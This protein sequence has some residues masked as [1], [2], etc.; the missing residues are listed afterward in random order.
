MKRLIKYLLLAFIVVSTSYLIAKE[1]GWL[2]KEHNKA[3]PVQIQSDGIFAYY[4]HGSKRCITCKTI[5]AYLNEAEDIKWLA[6]DVDLPENEHYIY[7]FNLASSTAV[8]AKYKDGKLLNF[9]VLP[10]VW[11]LVKD[12]PAFL[13]YVRTKT[14]SFIEK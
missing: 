13:E 6:V 14:K 8:I 11:K 10:D 5:E 9:E 3:S 12:K 7:D 1:T 4:F 2:A